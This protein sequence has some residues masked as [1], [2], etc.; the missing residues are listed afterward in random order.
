MAKPGTAL[1]SIFFVL[2]SGQI[3][4]CTHLMPAAQLLAAN[5]TIL[6]VVAWTRSSWATFMAPRGFYGII[7]DSYGP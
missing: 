2:V 5:C 6:L 4:V 1:L 3:V 7:A